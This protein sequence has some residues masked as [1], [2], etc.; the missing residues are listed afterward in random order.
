MPKKNPETESDRTQQYKIRIARQLIDR[1][2]RLG[3]DC[4]YSSGNEFA[5]DALDQ[6]AELLAELVKQQRAA[7]EVVRR[8]QLEEVVQKA[9]D[10]R[11]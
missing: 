2:T 1:L 8:R 9:K 10:G 7:Q 6:Y 3:R 4:G 11:R 5:A